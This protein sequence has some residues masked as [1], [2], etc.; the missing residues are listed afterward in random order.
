LHKFKNKQ[1]IFWQGL[2]GAVGHLCGNGK[3][4]EFFLK[5]SNHIGNNSQL[6]NFIWVS[7]GCKGDGATIKAKLKLKKISFRSVLKKRNISTNFYHSR[8]F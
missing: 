4:Q 3:A 1:N 6:K 5:K 8:S 2:R 7:V